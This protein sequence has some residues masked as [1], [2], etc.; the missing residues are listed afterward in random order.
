MALRLYFIVY[1]K[2]SLRFFHI[3]CRD[4]SLNLIYNHDKNYGTVEGVCGQRRI[5]LVALHSFSNQYD[6]S[7]LITGMIKHFVVLT[8]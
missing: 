6:T 4:F 7:K 3:F 1:N 8:S 2:Y 5:V